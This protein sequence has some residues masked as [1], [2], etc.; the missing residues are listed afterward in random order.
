M[1]TSAARAA[2]AAKRVENLLRARLEGEADEETRDAFLRAIDAVTEPRATPLT[3]AV[4]G[5]Y[6]WVDFQNHG[7][8][9]AFTRTLNDAFDLQFTKS[10]KARGGAAM[11][12]L[13]ERRRRVGVPVRHHAILCV[14]LATWRAGIAWR[15]RQPCGVLR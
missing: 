11:D 13:A 8:A 5:D 12:A 9:C 4:D 7:E 3:V 10:R 14:A 1:A 2:R 15:E 6:S